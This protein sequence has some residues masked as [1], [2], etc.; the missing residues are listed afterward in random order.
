MKWFKLA[1]LLGCALLVNKA[2]G[3]GFKYWD[4]SPSVVWDETVP[5][6]VQ[7]YI[8]DAAWSASGRS[9]LTISVDGYGSLALGKILFSVVP[10][11][12]MEDGVDGLMK[13]WIYTSRPEVM[14]QAHISIRQSTLSQPCIRRLVVHELWHALGSFGHSPH[15]ED[16]MY[17]STVWCLLS[18]YTLT[19]R[20]VTRLHSLYDEQACYAE[21]TDERELYIPYIDGWDVKLSPSTQDGVWNISRVFDS[22]GDCSGVHDQNAVFLSS[23]RNSDGDWGVS[24]QVVGE[25]VY[26]TRVIDNIGVMPWTSIRTTDSNDVGVIELPAIKDMSWK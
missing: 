6:D 2:Y 21:F 14:A 4:V 20:D 13:P 25:Q 23:V 19:S 5:E 22:Y 17:P 10:D 15:I 26:V 24:M 12:L 8:R 1:L 16:V 7:G 18:E 11:A 3:E 9:G